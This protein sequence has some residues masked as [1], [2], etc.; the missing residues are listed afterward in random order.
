MLLQHHFGTTI[1]RTPI[2]IDQSLICPFPKAFKNTHG[3]LA[4]ASD[5]PSQ[6]AGVGGTQLIAGKL[7]RPCPRKDSSNIAPTTSPPGIRRSGWALCDLFVMRKYGPSQSHDG[8]SGQGDP[9]GPGLRGEITGPLGTL[10]HQA[11]RHY[12]G[13][14]M[15][16]ALWKRQNN[17]CPVN[18]GISEEPK[19]V[20]N[21]MKWVAALPPRVMMSWPGLLLGPISGFMVLMQ[22]WFLLMSMAPAG[23]KGRENKAIKNWPCPSLAV[24]LGTNGPALHPWKHAGMR[25]GATPHLG[26]ISELTLCAGA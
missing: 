6:V 11:D 25:E 4:Q 22:P 17:S 10:Q 19:E 13:E 16:G 1:W 12:Q 21:G 5:A 9:Y 3:F 15:Y 26:S 24:T 20:R 18:R 8:L 7:S 23:T 14:Q 2:R